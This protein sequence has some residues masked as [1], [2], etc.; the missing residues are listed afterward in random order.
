MLDNNILPINNWRYTKKMDIKPSAGIKKCLFDKPEHNDLQTDLHEQLGDIQKADRLRWNYDFKRD[1]PLP[2]GRY[3]WERIGSTCR[4]FG[5]EEDVKRS[6]DE[7]DRC[8]SDAESETAESDSSSSASESASSTKSSTL[9]SPSHT[10]SSPS[11]QRCIPGQ[12]LCHAYF[13]LLSSL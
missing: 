5:F 13:H 9:N 12:F 3:N 2:G 8:S 7:V 6:S 4:G 11:T 1:Q 10:V